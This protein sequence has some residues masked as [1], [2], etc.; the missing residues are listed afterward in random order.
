MYGDASEWL[1]LIVRWI[2]IIAGI[3]WIGSSIFF[4]WLDRT[5][6]PPEGGP[7]KGVE[8]ELWMV[9][10]GGF[11]QVEKKLVAP[12][13]L[14]KTLHWFKWEAGFTWL[15]GM[16]LLLIVYHLGGSMLLVDPSAADTA[17]R[18]HAI[19]LLT[20]VVAWFVYDAIWR[21]PLAKNPDAAS[22]L[23]AA[24]CVAIAYGL[25]QVLSGRAA[26]LHLGAVIGTIMVANV[27]VIIIPAQRALVDAVKAGRAPDPDRARA[28]K[29]R[30]THNHYLTYPI[31]FIMI[32][33]HFPSTYGSS[34]NWAVLVAISLFGWGV[35]RWMN[36][37]HL[38]PQVL[39]AVLGVIGAAAVVA[40]LVPEET[41]EPAVVEKPVVAPSLKAI[42][43]VTTSRIAGRVIFEGAPPPP[44]PIA[45]PGE[46][47]KDRPTEIPSVLADGG[48]LG[49][50]IV[51]IREGLDGWRIPAATDEPLLID[52]KSCLF[53]PRVVAVRAGQPIRY[54]NSD[55]TLHNIRSLAKVNKNVNFVLPLAGMEQVRTF[56]EPELAVTL[57]CDV[58]PWMKA[59]V[60]VFDHPYFA[61]T[62]TQGT[63]HIDRVPPGEYLLEAWHESLGKQTAKV[64]VTASST[65]TADFRFRAQEVSP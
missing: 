17:V 51:Y 63:F 57:R 6:A 31:I 22:I 50:T 27:W 32:S 25:S 7:K 30:S 20:P 9:H 38:T 28:A 41:V 13:A 62:E 24:L 60:A 53:A 8:G 49:E 19:G 64:S 35:K 37:V 18:A 44:K 48:G 21:S 61:M 26:Y 34:W 3:M 23:S 15:S 2:H 47:G 36:A 52:Q 55:P 54:L 45:L 1:N 65:V 56:K 5:L 14:P 10:S 16:L 58:H 29:Q 42:D 46:C 39:L 11:Y 12:E 43:P 59:S 33:H 40:R 4:H